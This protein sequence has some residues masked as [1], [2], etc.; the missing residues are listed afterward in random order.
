MPI[1]AS[2]GTMKIPAELPIELNTV[3]FAPTSIEFDTASRQPQ[4]Q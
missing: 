1:I 4:A 2:P 3:R